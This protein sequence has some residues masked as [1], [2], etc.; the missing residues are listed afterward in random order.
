[1]ADTTFII[2]PD[3]GTGTDYTNLYSFE[4]TEQTTIASGDRYLV[5]CRCTGGTADTASTGCH[6]DGWT[7]NGELKIYTTTTYR[8]QGIYPTSGNI[9]RIE[10]TSSWMNPIRVYEPNVT[11]EG[12][13]A[14][15]TSA[16]KQAFNVSTSGVNQKFISCYAD[17]NNNGGRC[18][19]ATT[20]N[21]GDSTYF[22]NC[23]AYNGTFGFALGAN[24]SS[25]TSYQYIY[26]NTVSDCTDDAYRTYGSNGNFYIKNNIAQNRA[27]S[28]YFYDCYGTLNDDTN[29][30][31]IDNYHTNVTTNVV[32]G[33]VTFESG[34]GNLNLS[35]SDTVVKGNGLD[36]SNDSNFAFDYDYANKKRSVWDLGAHQVTVSG[37]HLM[38]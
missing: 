13:A 15:V 38:L 21:S 19:N 6:I 35:P 20:D 30:V 24:N 7:I 22:I 28:G 37:Y 25:G 34:T 11:I 5:E 18:F 23:I 16:G 17:G 3:N 8:H 14:K 1:M 10:T 27:G 29:N 32:V 4:A 31:E 36:L 12:I 2:D 33:S 26:N 9:Y